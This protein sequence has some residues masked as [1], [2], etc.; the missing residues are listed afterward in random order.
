M[1]S[2]VELVQLPAQ[3]VLSIRATIP[4]ARLGEAMGERI[5]ALSQ[6]LREH[7]VRPA[8]PPYVRYH[9]FGETDTDMEFGVPVAQP[10]TGENR[11]VGGELPAGPAVT[12]WHLGPHDR[13]GE[14]YG[15]IESWRKDHGRA[16]AGPAW[17]VYHW[18]DLAATDE[19]PAGSD[20]S[21]W[22]VQLV[23]PIT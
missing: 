16:P 20:P 8:G 15:R 4:V 14:A 1:T 12:T 9:T 18:I 5:S 11:I 19:S 22:R 13:L 23:Q 21:T 3:P 17:E 10:A 7:G 2:T 6:F